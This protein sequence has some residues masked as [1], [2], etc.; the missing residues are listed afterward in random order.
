MAR[1]QGK[2]KSDAERPTNK[3]RGLERVFA[4]E[5]I[6]GDRNAAQV[7]QKVLEAVRKRKEKYQFYDP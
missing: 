2:K 5:V 6:V 1:V 7:L 3:Y 4:F